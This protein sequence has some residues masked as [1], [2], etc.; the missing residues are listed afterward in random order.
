[1]QVVV[2]VDQ[3]GGPGRGLNRPQGAVAVHEVCDMIVLNH[4]SRD[5]GCGEDQIEVIGVVAI[6]SHEVFQRLRRVSRQA[7]GVRQIADLDI[8]IGDGDVSREALR[9]VLEAKLVLCRAFRIEAICGSVA[10]VGTSAR[11][12]SAMAVDTHDRNRTAKLLRRGARWRR[13]AAVIGNS[14]KVRTSDAPESAT[15]VSRGPAT[16]DE[17]AIPKAHGNCRYTPRPPT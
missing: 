15:A 16:I 4:E 9:L 17:T 1:M 11:A 6:A 13:A 12:T 7:V 2:Q 3:H 8:E 14:R 10:G 5:A